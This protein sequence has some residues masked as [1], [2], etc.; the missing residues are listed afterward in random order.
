MLPSTKIGYLSLPREIRDQIMELALHPGKVYIPAK[1]ESV[2]KHLN[3]FGEHPSRGVHHRYGVQLLATCRQVYE[4]G[5]TIWYGKNTFHVT[6]CSFDEM[7]LVLGVYQKKHLDTMKRLVV[8]CTIQDVSQQSIDQLNETLAAFWETINRQHPNAMPIDAG[9]WCHHYVNGKF[10]DKVAAAIKK[11]WRAKGL[12]LRTE[13]P[14]SPRMLVNEVESSW[15][16]EWPFRYRFVP[17][18][19]LGVNLIGAEM[20]LVMGS[21]IA[22]QLEEDDMFEAIDQVLAKLHVGDERYPSDERW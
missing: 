9:T 12:W 3:R 8:D 10:K 11:E 4:E 16:V 6:T 1:L 15:P 5:H 13:T 17:E 22:T 14:N 18:E 20:E 19:D 2:M 21:T 7:K